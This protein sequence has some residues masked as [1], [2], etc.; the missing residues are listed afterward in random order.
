MNPLQPLSRNASVQTLANRSRQ[1]LENSNSPPPY[2]QHHKLERLAWATIAGFYAW[3][4]PTL[5][6]GLHQMAADRVDTLERGP[7]PVQTYPGAEIAEPALNLLAKTSVTLKGTP[8]ISPAMDI[9]TDWYLRALSGMLFF[10][11]LGLAGK[12]TVK[13]SEFYAELRKKYGLSGKGM[14][15]A[16]IDSG[17]MPTRHLKAKNMVFHPD[18]LKPEVVSKRFFD[19]IGHGTGTSELIAQV[20]PEAKFHIYPA[21]TTKRV[22]TVYKDL[23]RYAGEC[24]KN[25]ESYNKQE[26]RKILSPLVDSIGNS[27]KSASENGANVINISLGAQPADAMA[28]GVWVMMQMHF[29]ADVAIWAI[30]NWRPISKADHPEKPRLE[31]EYAEF[32]KRHAAIEAFSKDMEGLPLLIEDIKECFGPVYDALD[33]AQQHGATVVLAAGN[34]GGTDASHK[35]PFG[36]LNFLGLLDHPALTV[37]GSTTLDGTVS[38]FSSEWTNDRQPEYA[39]VG[40]GEFALEAY[41]PPRAPWKGPLHAVGYLLQPFKGLAHRWGYQHPPGTSFAAPHV[42]GLTLLMKEM[43]K[44]YNTSM[45]THEI[46]RIIA[47]TANPAR[48]SEEHA[49]KI[50]EE[51]EKS[52]AEQ[53]PGRTVTESAINQEIQA[54]LE[55]RIGKGLVNYP[56][57]LAQLAENIGYNPELVRQGTK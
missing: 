44:T 47:A 33:V 17:A 22:N 2:K 25:P 42:A 15:V 21:L 35:K 57:A 50:R 10:S 37:V 30:S 9:Y 38:E 29:W 55:R 49:K 26:V 39:G 54:E 56:A 20:G 51:V 40:S 24:S 12:K 45:T 53:Y 43:L 7:I 34:D 13:P 32:E 28:Q 16:V 5:T 3:S 36:N 41:T 48:F 18:P 23:F 31:A 19:D 6:Q 1:N 27:I 4:G 46:E 52:L 11:A 14:T 8:V